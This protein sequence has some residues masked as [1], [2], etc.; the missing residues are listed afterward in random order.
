MR[1]GGHL[2][3]TLA[4][5]SPTPFVSLLP[6]KSTLVSFVLRFY[7]PDQGTVLIDGHDVKSMNVHNL[8]SHIAYVGQVRLAWLL[9]RGAHTVDMRQENKSR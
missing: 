7:D 9:P 1:P 6:G 5:S 3:L 8:R 4:D 2:R